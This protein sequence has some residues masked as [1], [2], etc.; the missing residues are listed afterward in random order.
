MEEFYT[1]YLIFAAPIGKL[2]FCMDDIDEM[3]VRSTKV[4]LRMGSMSKLLLL[5]IMLRWSPEM[6]PICDF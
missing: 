6:L 1:E 4:E 3:E 5:S 2:L